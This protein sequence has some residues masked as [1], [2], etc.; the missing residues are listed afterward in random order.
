MSALAIAGATFASIAAV[1]LLGMWLRAFLPDRYLSAESK[2]VVSLATALIATLS[3]VL[4]GLLISSTRTS[5]E[6]KRNQVIRMTADLIELDLLL[7]DYGPDAQPA[8]QAM[9]NAVPLMIDSIWRDGAG[10]FRSEANAAPDAGAEAV[11]YELQALAPRD[12]SQRAHRDRALLV[13]LD[14]AWPRSSCSCS[15]SPPTRFQRRSSPCWYCGSASSSGPSRCTRA[16]TRCSSLSCSSARWWR[17]ARSSS[18][19]IWTAPSPACCRSPARRSATPCRRWR[20]RHE[21]ARCNAGCGRA[22]GA[23]KT[24]I[25][26]PLSPGG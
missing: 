19:W 11:L 8:R 13:G 18:S 17:R 5:Y 25:S 16:P 6:E 21:A 14:L 24:E 1:T 9:R 3:A 7:K 4:L 23:E 2:Q 12:D 10:R 26:L 20:R 15:P 22:T